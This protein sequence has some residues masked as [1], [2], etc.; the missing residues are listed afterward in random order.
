M[1]VWIPALALV[2]YDKLAVSVSSNILEQVVKLPQDFFV[3][4]Q[5]S[6]T[7]YNFFGRF[8]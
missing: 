2:D 8:C 3:S 7:R 5:K 6:R 4:V 1:G